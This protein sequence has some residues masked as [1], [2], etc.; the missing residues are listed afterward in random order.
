MP[1]QKKSEKIK[2]RTSF[3]HFS[4]RYDKPTSVFRR[5]MAWIEREVNGVT[6]HT[7]T[8]A[9]SRDYDEF[10]KDEDWGMT[11]WA[12]GTHPRGNF[13]ELWLRWKKDTWEHI[14]TSSP[15][16]SDMSFW[17]VGGTE[18]TNQF[19][20]RVML[21]HIKSGDIFIF[22]IVHMSLDNTSLRAEVWKDSCSGLYDL[23][24]NDKAKHPDAHQV[25]QG[26]INK[27]WR[28]NYDR[29]LCVARLERPNKMTCSWRDNVP[30]TGGTHGPRGIID[31]TYVSR[32]LTVLRCKLVTLTALLRRASDHHPY[33]VKVGWK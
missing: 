25:L 30:R 14:K 11:R 16:T 7:G 5:A 29:G 27:N 26:D 20:L 32:G 24:Q 9:S 23:F 10:Y 13:R 2:Y 33:K 28:E 3:V 6:I 22:Y 21:R 19:A 15:K 8:E 18:V 17:R 12:K 1:K 4:G 31:H